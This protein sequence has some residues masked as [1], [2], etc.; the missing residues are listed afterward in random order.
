MLER[1]MKFWKMIHAKSNPFSSISQL[2]NSITSKGSEELANLVVVGG[3][4][5]LEG[6]NTCTADMDVE[7]NTCMLPN[8]S[9]TKSNL[10]LSALLPSNPFPRCIVV[11]RLKLNVFHNSQSKINQMECISKIYDR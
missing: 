4:K 3:Y 1:Y 2:R 10:A 6:N 8:G 11:V 7:W 9:T 5:S